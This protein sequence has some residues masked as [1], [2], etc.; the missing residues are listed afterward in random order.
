MTRVCH[1]SPLA[2]S[3]AS[4][5]ASSRSLIGSLVIAALGR[6]RGFGDFPSKSAADSKNKASSEGASSRSFQIA[7]NERF[8]SF[9]GFSHTNDPANAGSWCSNQDNQP[10]I[11][12]SN[13]DKTGFL[14]VDSYRRQRSPPPMVMPKDVPD[15]LSTC[16][17]RQALAPRFQCKTT[18]GIKALCVVLQLGRIRAQSK[19]WTSHEQQ[20]I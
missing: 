8:F 5:A 4:T 14:I 12:P 17:K 3:A 7:G 18:Q 19:Q 9:I 13:T 6:P 1:P 15:W 20:D 10:L 11:K 2:R 16:C